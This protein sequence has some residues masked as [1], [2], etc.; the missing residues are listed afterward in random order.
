M[1]QDDD[2]AVAGETTAKI[3]AMRTLC[4]FGRST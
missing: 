2:V 4:V 3:D 1:E